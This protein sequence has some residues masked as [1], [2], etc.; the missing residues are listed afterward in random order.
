MHQRNIFSQKT[1]CKDTT[2]TDVDIY[3]SFVLRLYPSLLEVELLFFYLFQFL[4]AD[5]RS[6]FVW[7]V[8]TQ[9]FLLIKCVRHVIQRQFSRVNLFTTHFLWDFSITFY[10]NGLSVQFSIK[11]ETST[12]YLS[13][14][15]TVWFHQSFSNR[16]S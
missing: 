7:L 10:L 16:T 1:R 3:N 12:F 4:E 9:L 2:Y 8:V 5:E 14:Y 13:T 15:P 6:F 11:Y